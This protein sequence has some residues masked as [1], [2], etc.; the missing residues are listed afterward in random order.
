MLKVY[1]ISAPPAGGTRG[2][3]TD[4]LVG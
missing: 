2:D 1:T 3:E 4:I